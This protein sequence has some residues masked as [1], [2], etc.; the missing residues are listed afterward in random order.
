MRYIVAFAFE[1]CPCSVGEILCSPGG[2]FPFALQGCLDV[3]MQTLRSILKMPSIDMDVSFSPTSNPPM[4]W[5]TRC[6]CKT[7]YSE[8]MVS[9]TKAKKNVCNMVKSV[10]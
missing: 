9:M 8:A 4:H 6:I 1:C 7:R 3:K 2:M 10:E 5:C